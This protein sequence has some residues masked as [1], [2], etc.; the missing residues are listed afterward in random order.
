MA[1]S[2]DETGVIVPCPACG[3]ANRVKFEALDAKTRC[4]ACKADLPAIAQPAEIASEGRFD[5]L[6]ARARVPVLVDFWAPWCGPCHAVAPEVEKV[7]SALRGRLI[8]VKVNT[9]AVPELGS[10]YVVRS[11]PT[12]AVFSGG[13]EID[14]VSGAIPAAEIVKLV[15]RAQ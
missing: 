12:L 14:R 9:D 13:R 2:T 15:E 3:T 4:A 1:L 10:R 11:I 5:A 7:A 8:V 6:L